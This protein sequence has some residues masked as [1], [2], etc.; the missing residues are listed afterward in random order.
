MECG[1]GIAERITRFDPTFLIS[2]GVT[3]YMA[4]KN[5]LTFASFHS[6]NNFDPTVD[7]L[8]TFRSDLV[9]MNPSNPVNDLL[10]FL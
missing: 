9:V 8:G 3:S 6:T 1:V 2:S 7:L 10:D 5:I 4:P